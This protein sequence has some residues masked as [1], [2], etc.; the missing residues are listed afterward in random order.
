MAIKIIDDYTIEYIADGSDVIHELNYKHNYTNDDVDKIKTVYI[1][2]YKNGWNTIPSRAFYNFKGLET[3]IIETT[4]DLEIRS[5]AFRNCANLTTFKFAN[6]PYKVTTITF[7]SSVFAFTSI[8]ELSFP[9]CY[10]YF[11]VAALE[12]MEKL[13]HLIFDKSRIDRS[14]S[15]KIFQ[16]NSELK[17]VDIITDKTFNDWAENY[18]IIIRA[19]RYLYRN[20]Y[21]SEELK[22]RSNNKEVLA[23]VD[24]NSIVLKTKYDPTIA[25]GDIPVFED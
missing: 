16:S 10:L 6:K 24:E 2:A 22:V 7:R 5:E 14:S 4:G 19:L 21:T 1:T 12:Y 8:K 11:D 3:V 15:W 23:K 13:E 20:N 18:F 17:L 25:L 9:E